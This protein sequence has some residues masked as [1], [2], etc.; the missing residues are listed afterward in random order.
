MSS[1]NRLRDE[2]IVANGLNL[3][4]LDWGDSR[5]RDAM[6][7]VHGFAETKLVWQD[8]APEMAREHRVIAYDQRGH[9]NSERASDNDYSRSSQVEDL[10][11][12]IDGLGLRSVILVGHSMGGANA[13]CYAAEHPDTVTAMVI[14]ETAPEI[15]RTGLETM[16]RLVTVSDEFTNLD[17]VIDIYRRHYPYSTVEQLERR[18]KST[19]TV[20]EDGGYTWDFDIAFRDSMMRPPDPDPGQR[21]LNDLWECVDR[22][23][24]PVM[25]VRGSETDMLSPEAIQ[26]LQR[27]IIGSRV[28]LIEDAGHAVPT[29]QPSALSLNIREFLQTL[30][31]NVG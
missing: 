14:I 24:C 25:I 28:S 15:L 31:S 7:M 10:A 8:V 29:D 21:R 11:S 18:V 1:S 4:Y 17:Q 26:R 22:V 9:G 19:M 12:L 6:V 16:R 23:Q 5:T 30:T 2:M 13:I 20:T 27:R 3:S